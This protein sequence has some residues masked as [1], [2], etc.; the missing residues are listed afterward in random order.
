VALDLSYQSIDAATQ[1]GGFCCGARELDRFFTT[2]KALRDHRAGTILTTCAYLPGVAPPVG[3]YSIASVAESVKHLPGTYRLFGGDDYFPALQLVYLGVQRAHQGQDIGTSMAGAVV[4]LFADVGQKL[5]I[6]H[7]ILV[8]LNDEVIPFYRDRLG[9]RCY[10][11]T[12][13]MY[14]P[15]QLAV[16]AMNTPPENPTGELFPNAQ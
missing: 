1:T 2:G 10:K 16:D 4:E 9:F 12:S 15:L 13:R 8:P 6:P 14:L 5:G 3:F 7:L 11:G